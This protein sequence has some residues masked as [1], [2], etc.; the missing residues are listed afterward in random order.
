MT[1]M[2]SVIFLLYLFLGSLSIFSQEK[3]A[4][5]INSSN[6]NKKETVK[7]FKK[8]SIFKD[9]KAYYKSGNYD[10]V[11]DLIQNTFKEYPESQNDADFLGY[12]MNSQFQ[13]YLLENRRLY[14]NGKGDT[15]KLF[16]HIY[17]TYENGLKCDSVSAIP[18]KKGK[19]ITKYSSDI[20]SHLSYLRNNLKSGGLFYL[21][22]QKYNDAFPFFSM[23]INT[24]S[25]P[26]VYKTKNGIVPSDT[27]SVRIYKMALHAAYGSNRHTDVMRFLPVAISDTLRK[28]VMMEMGAE[29]SLQLRDSA[30]FVLLLIT[31]FD[32][33]PSNDYFRAN[34]IKLYHDHNDFDNTMKVLDRCIQTDSLDAKYWK[35]KGNEYYVIDSLDAAI[36]PYTHAVNI[37]STDVEILTKLGHIY[38]RKA[39]DF[40]N[41]A[42]LKIG[43]PDFS[44][45]R[46]LLTDLYTNAMNYYERVRL[47]RPQDSQLWKSALRECYYRLNKGDE[48]KLLESTKH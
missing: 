12:A 1:F 39:R 31:G 6:D 48:L 29:S 3:N 46:R 4:S 18:D 44:K 45:N 21:K 16:S 38:I 36:N 10:R 17:N 9:I 13:L 24:M 41:S 42:N 35:L 2:R 40:Y 22:K 33:Y 43:S 27:D 26:I 47:L 14:L 37:D 19:I 7:V 23:Y 30:T 28:D 32:E 20:N 34:L 5:I 8:K 25:N 11:Y 15:V